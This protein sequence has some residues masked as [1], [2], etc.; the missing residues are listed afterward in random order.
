MLEDLGMELIYCYNFPDAIDYFLERNEKEAKSLMVR[1]HAL[2]RFPLES[3]D[4]KDGSCEYFHA[5][6][7]YEQ[8]ATN[9][10]Q[11]LVGNLL[12]KTMNCFFR[13]HFQSRNGRLY[14]CI[15]CSLSR[16]FKTKCGKSY[17]KH[18]Y[19][20]EYKDKCISYFS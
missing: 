15:S 7:K 10:N 19:L 17:C 16:S 18:E 6:K 12:F 11:F 4:K 9:R 5:K 13:L 20:Y 3:R 8:L 1:M 2:E 14:K